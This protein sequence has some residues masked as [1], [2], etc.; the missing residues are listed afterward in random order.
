MADEKKLS[1]KLEYLQNTGTSE[2]VIKYLQYNEESI[3]HKM[4]VWVGRALQYKLKLLEQLK[5][6]KTEKVP[7][8]M[9]LNDDT[10]T[11][12]G[13]YALDYDN[14]ALDTKTM[15]GKL[16][17]ELDE[18]TL[19][20]APIKTVTMIEALRYIQDWFESVSPNLSNYTIESAYEESRRWHSNL[21]NQ[22]AVSDY[23]DDPDEKNVVYRHGNFKIVSIT[24]NHDL[25]IEG[26]KMGHCV[27]GGGYYNR[28]SDAYKILSVRD[29]KNEPHATIEL[30]GKFV[31]Q[32]KGKQ[33]KTPIDKYIPI[34]VL[35]II[36]RHLDVTDCNDFLNFPEE[37]MIDGQLY[38]LIKFEII[39]EN[40]DDKS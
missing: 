15:D 6:Q 11:F 40:I 3:H 17:D 25:Q 19:K 2:E 28:L 36:D 10:S 26:A 34:I 8:G 38:E 20:V 12:L 22:K 13:I 30:D 39:E 23:K 21:A 18:K 5:N 33:N 7:Y 1:K 32:I 14:D 29:E 27:G 9:K 37:L 24:K 31:R 4:L 16:I 35:W